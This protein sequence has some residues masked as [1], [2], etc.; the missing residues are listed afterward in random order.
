MADIGSIEAGSVA[1]CPIPSSTKQP[2]LCPVRRPGRHL[3]GRS[4]QQATNL[5][6]ERAAMRH[7]V[8]TK[9][10]VA[11]PPA[12]AP[13]YQQSRPSFPDLPERAV[14]LLSDT[15]P[16][17]FFPW[18]GHHPEDALNE[19]TTRNGFYDKLPASQNESLT[20]RPS[21]L[22]SLK[23][24]SGLHILSSV[25]ASALDQRELHGTITAANTFKPPPR[26]TL[27]DTKKEAWLRDLADP[28]IPLRRLSRT[29]PHGIRGK[30]SLDHCLSNH[31]PISRAI[32]LVK[33]VGANEIRACKRK[34][35]SGAFAIGG[36][37]KWI[38]DWTT[39]VEQ[40]LE[41]IIDNCGSECWKININYGLRLVSHI[42]AEHLLDREEY[43]KW[44]IDHLK[45][46]DLD[47][48]PVWLLIMN[49]YKQDLL[50]YRQHGM[51]LAKALLTQL[52]LAQKP[53]NKMVYD[54]VF[55]ELVNECR[56]LL[57]ATP[58]CFL[59]P[60]CWRTY[61]DIIQDYVVPGNPPLANQFSDLARRNQ[62]LEYRAA[63]QNAK[64][65]T[66]PEQNIIAALDSLARTPDYPKVASNCLGTARNS[67][68]LVKTC[69]QWASSTYRYGQDRT[70]AAA[71]LLRI[72]NEHSVD[73]Q[74]PLLD[75]MAYSRHIPNIDQSEFHRLC[76][77]L[78]SS[79]HLS[80]GRY[81]QWL[82]ARG[83]FHKDHE[84][85]LG[86][87]LGVRLLRELPL[88]GLPAHVLNL[89]R[90]LLSS[91]GFSVEQE[92]AVMKTIQGQIAERLPGLFSRIDHVDGKQTR[93]IHLQHLSRTL[94]SEV[95]WWIRKS[96]ATSWEEQKQQAQHSTQEPVLRVNENDFTIV[97]QV[98]EDL[99]EHGVFV[100]ILCVLAETTRNR[101]LL[102][103]IT[104]TVNYHFDT[105]DALGAT[106]HLFNILFSQRKLFQSREIVETSFI[107]ALLDLATCL[108][109]TGPEIRRLQ[110]EEI[111]LDAKQSA[112]APSPISDNMVEAVHS[113]N[114]TFFEEMDQ[115]LL[116][117]TS[118]DQLTLAR[119]FGTVMDHLEKSWEVGDAFPFRYPESL[120][121]LRAFDR[122]SFDALATP[123]LDCLMS[124]ATRPRLSLILVPLICHN[125]C[126]LSFLMD[127]VS[128]IDQKF[129][130][131]QGALIALELLEILSS[132]HSLHMPSM[133][134]KSYRFLRQRNVI[135][136]THSESVVPLIYRCI[137]AAGTLDSPVRSQAEKL[138]R[139]DPVKSFIR[140]LISQI[141]I[142]DKPISQ[143]DPAFR[144][145][146]RAI[147]S[148]ED[149][150][151]FTTLNG[152]QKLSRLLDN[153]S[154][155]N[156][157]FSQLSL[158]TAIESPLESD[159]SMSDIF[160]DILVEKVKRAPQSQVTLWSH[161]LSNLSA[162]GTLSIHERAVETILSEIGIDATSPL[163]ESESSADS[164]MDIVVTTSVSIPE[165]AALSLIGQVLERLSE[166][167]SYVLPKVK[168]QAL[169]P[170][171]EKFSKVIDILLRLLATH[172]AT[173]LNP[174]FPQ[175]RLAQICMSLAW[176]HLYL[177]TSHIYLA[178][179]IFDILAILSDSLSQDTR[180]RCVQT[181]FGCQG[182]QNAQ[183]NFVFGGASASSAGEWLRLVSEA[184][185]V[186]YA[187]T[188]KPY[189]LRPWEMMQD[190]TP[191]VT[192]NDTSL[193]LTLFA[194]RKS[195]L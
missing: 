90:S 188:R 81:F 64:L 179:R 63:G 10:Y 72:W 167:V 165:G 184:A 26:V 114:P 95:A 54:V 88:H 116:N 118:M 134:Y 43:C 171:P 56:A 170:E 150:P 82:M 97:R 186:P 159:K 105:F 168:E 21:V 195:V 48:L 41:A 6:I 25:F 132:Q 191:A 67:D 126:T 38:K 19:L 176:L 51:P 86:D 113:D 96:I 29:I 5:A 160:A 2:S 37:A 50:R 78:V 68:V 65:H 84:N 55:R 169:Q 112:A 115:I 62:K 149:P 57:S 66:S 101:A 99:Q 141:S 108:P 155:F 36:E 93:V 131:E 18:T 143:H 146:L 27:T 89:R 47:S 189:P 61:L 125:V 177:S 166:L 130:P 11:E 85:S 71:R 15:E 174:K 158:E 173:I 75:F 73:L 124:R 147:L 181:L 111:S 42:Y 148:L 183:V 17:D 83:A 180:S 92:D 79:K 53:V 185:P 121:R 138:L 60:Q 128:T 172:Q 45:T 33:C 162:D 164:L 7:D 154:Y 151:E 52:N 9:A 193:S 12:S 144:S 178:K 40:F 102:T 157:R 74:G 140:M 49:I 34:G 127:R 59:L 13:R 32:W 194:V 139:S 46:C 39:N 4:K 175:T 98:F 91:I 161:L 135:L 76:A 182:L 190:A 20:A 14:R 133:E 117:R 122:K 1:R 123:W 187:K 142:A 145:A 22:S 156:R 136:Q 153:V 107:H 30:A 28:A 58:D 3:R 8:Q 77:E 70:Y 192:E 35:T 94:K 31:I 110:K 129:A 69:L 24:K 106:K 16:A 103:A 137:Q 119:C 163:A 23:N 44:L 104:D 152:S 87:D 120:S 80:V 100:D 109:N